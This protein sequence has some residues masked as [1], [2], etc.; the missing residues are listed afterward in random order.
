MVVLISALSADAAT[1]K[2]VKVL[3][4]LLDLKGRHTLSPSLFDRDSYQGFL[5]L[6]PDQ[7]SSIQYDVE[8]KAK[9]APQGPLKVRLET[10]GVAR[11]EVPVPFVMEREVQGKGWFS[12][13][14]T[15]QLTKE[16]YQKLSSVTAWRV[17]L[18]EGTRLLGE[19]KSFLW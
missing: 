6:H 3:P 19:Q 10:R 4:H 8:W 17:T 5:R 2:V 16:E 13:W 14:A 11:G 7:I 18:W 1:G 9:G 12:H 15:L